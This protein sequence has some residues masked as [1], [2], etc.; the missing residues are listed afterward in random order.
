MNIFFLTRFNAN[1]IHL[2]SGSLYHIYKNITVISFFI[3]LH[4]KGLP[5]AF[6]LHKIVRH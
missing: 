4:F 5:S 2:W 1:D 3:T 6:V